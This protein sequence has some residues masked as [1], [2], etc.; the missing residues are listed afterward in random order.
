[1]D[2]SPSPTAGGIMQYLINLPTA[3]FDSGRFSQLLI[4][5]DPSAVLDR[6]ADTLSLRLSTCLSSRE[7]QRLGEESG[8]ALEPSAITLLPS[9]CCGGCGG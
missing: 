5:E 4:A 8:L 2:L 7:L 1:M 3:P 9:D 6:I